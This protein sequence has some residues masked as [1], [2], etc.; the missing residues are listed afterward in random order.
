MP[1]HDHPDMT[2]FIK[3]LFGEILMKTYEFVTEDG[4]P[5]GTSLGENI[6]SKYTADGK[7]GIVLF[8]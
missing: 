6:V 4:H 1:L 2:V 8:L 5:C 7:K 3:L